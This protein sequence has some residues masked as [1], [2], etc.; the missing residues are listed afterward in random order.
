MRAGE[1]SS[2]TVESSQAEE[3]KSGRPYDL[4]YKQTQT[5]IFRQGCGITPFLVRRSIYF[6]LLNHLP[7]GG[8]TAASMPAT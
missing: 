4:G 6:A 3:R 8:P 1:T 2:V 5:S 7:F